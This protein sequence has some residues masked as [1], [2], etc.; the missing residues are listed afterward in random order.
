MIHPGANEASPFAILDILEAS[1]ADISHTVFAHMDRTIQSNE[2]VLRLAKKGVWLEYDL[3]G[4]EVSHYQVSYFL[5]LSP[6]SIPGQCTLFFLNTTIYNRL[7]L[8]LLNLQSHK[9]KFLLTKYVNL[10]YS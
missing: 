4:T 1:G 9:N 10:Y 8:R 6:G 3:F 7:L 5:L 2:V